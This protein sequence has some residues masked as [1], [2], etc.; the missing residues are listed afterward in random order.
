MVEINELV[1]EQKEIVKREAINLWNSNEFTR[2][3]IEAL[4]KELVRMSRED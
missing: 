2:D 3:M 4:G 1:E